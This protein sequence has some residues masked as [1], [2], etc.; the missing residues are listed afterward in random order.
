MCKSVGPQ[1]L[2]L[3]VRDCWEKDI[4]QKMFPGY[5]I[6][7]R[8]QTSVTEFLLSGLV[9]NHNLNGIFFVFFLF[10]Y[11]VTL[12][13]NISMISL[14]CCSSTLRNPMYFFLGHLSFSDICYSSVITPKIISNM[15]S[16]Q[17]VISFNGCA[18][19]LFFFCLFGGTECFLVTVMAYDRYV[20]ICN[21]LLY[22]MIMSRDLL[23]KLVGIVYSSGF[24]LSAIQTGC[25]FRLSFCNSNHVKHFFC[26]IPA[27]LKLSCTNTFISEIIMFVLSGLLGTFSVFIIL[28]SYAN[29]ISSILKM[30]S[31]EGRHKAFSTCSSHLAVVTLFFGTALFVYS[32]P[33]SSYSIQKDNILSVFYTVVIPMLNPIIYC[34][35]NA[36][37][38]AAF[39]KTIPKTFGHGFN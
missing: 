33:I 29:I 22:V 4:E 25:T 20:A 23:L 26:D 27:L 30:Q 19:Q 21:P 9:D 11:L 31:S 8:N 1:L 18:A 24:L 16:R 14:I 17:M 37:V 39:M 2:M 5:S 32:R 36:Q 34:L 38:K 28:I 6:K 13:C 3:L 35:R 12:I 10:I 15:V 7:K